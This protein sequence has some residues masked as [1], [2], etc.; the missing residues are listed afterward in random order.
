MSRSYNVIP[1]T[2]QDEMKQF[3]LTPEQ[4]LVHL[5]LLICHETNLIGAFSIHPETISWYTS[6][7]VQDVKKALDSLE[8]R[9][10]IWQFPGFWFFVRLRWLCEPTKNSKTYKGAYAEY[11]KLPPELQRVIRSVHDDIVTESRLIAER[12]LNISPVKKICEI[13]ENSPDLPD[14]LENKFSYTDFGSV[15]PQ[16]RRKPFKH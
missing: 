12:E 8:T 3:E 1:I 14:I 6:L 10:L 9:E 7:S 15:I 16:K 2:F 11:L 5:H 13:L 4:S